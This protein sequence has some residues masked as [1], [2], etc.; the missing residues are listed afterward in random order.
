MNH[1]D[2]GEH[3]T[4]EAVDPDVPRKCRRCNVRTAI[5]TQRLRVRSTVPHDSLGAEY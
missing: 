3:E 2:L 5:V 4:S 1:R